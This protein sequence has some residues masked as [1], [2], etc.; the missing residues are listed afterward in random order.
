MTKK[1][2]KRFCIII[3]IIIIITWGF[4]FA[5]W[6]INEAK[7]NNATTSVI[8][9]ENNVD[10]IKQEN[11]ELEES[12]ED[13][14]L[15]QQKN[16]E[17]RNS[18]NTP[19]GIIESVEANPEYVEI[20]EQQLLL[21]PPQLMKSFINDGWKIKMENADLGKK[22]FLD[23]GDTVRAFVNPNEKSIIIKN[24]ENAAFFSVPHEFGHYLDIV[25]AY[26]STTDEF[27]EIY[28]EEVETF[29]CQRD[30]GD[31]TLLTDEGE[32]FAE[33]FEYLLRNPSKCTPRAR[34]YVQQCIYEFIRSGNGQSLTAQSFI[35]NVF[36]NYI[37]ESKFL[38]KYK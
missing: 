16:W 9:L 12:N 27:K 8:K 25:M 31:E 10:V 13:I 11:L 36:Y 4:I 32:F 37:V 22:Y 20:A 15:V 21:I 33:T 24:S 26:P 28:Q 23:E 35:Y 7:P 29:K 30:F 3:T 34:E 38:L 1:E 6:I 2:E 14:L 19:Y 18:I 17:A 5:I